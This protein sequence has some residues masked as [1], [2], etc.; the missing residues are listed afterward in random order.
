MMGDYF[1]ALL[2]SAGVAPARAG[3]GGTPAPS[4]ADIGVEV[5]TIAAADGGTAEVQRGAVEEGSSTPSAVQGTRMAVQPAV[6]QQSAAPA[7]PATQPKQPADA[8]E[9]ALHPAVRAALH[10]VA[11]DPEAARESSPPAPRRLAPTPAPQPSARPSA[12]AQPASRFDSESERSPSP[13]AP[14]PPVGRP[15]QA[16][17]TGALADAPFAPRFGT[18]NGDFVAELDVAFDPLPQRE[19]GR[20]RNAAHPSAQRKQVEISIGSMHV[21]VDPPPPA[22][23][24]ATPPPL[25][26][27]VPQRTGAVRGSDTSFARSRLPRF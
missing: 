19:P 13:R 26:Q 6:A 2:R 17:A 18:A 21:R 5:E 16:E 1:G 8:P 3:D 12:I 7:S 4:V 24:A 9:G 14:A 11:A 23:V 15:P 22:V 10:W 20:S 27:P 25:P